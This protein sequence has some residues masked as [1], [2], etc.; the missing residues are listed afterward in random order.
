[1]RN[2]TRL[3][4]L[5]MILSIC[6]QNTITWANTHNLEEISVTAQKY[7]QDPQSV[8]ISLDHFSEV[9]LEDSKINNLFDLLTFSPNTHMLER[10]CEHI[11]VIRGIS[12]FRGC[13]YSPAAFYV[14]EVSYPLHYMQNIELFEL[15]RAEILK[16]PQGTL[17]GRNAESGV[18]SLFTKQP[19]NQVNGNIS[20]DY[21]NYNTLRTIAGVSGPVIEDKLFLGLSGMYY[22]TNGYVE[23]IANGDDKAADKNRASGRANLRW[24]PSESWD[25]S[26]LADFIT[27]DDHG[28]E[29]RVLSGPMATEPHKNRRDTDAFL[30]QDWNS[31]TLRA[32]YTTDT[33]KVVSVTNTLYQTLEKVNDA[34]LWDNPGMKAINPIDMTERQYSQELRVSST[35][36]SPLQWLLGAYGFIE[37]SHFDYRYE[38]LSA[39]SIYMRPVTDVD[40]NGYA[41]FGQATYTMF[42]KLHLTLGLRFDHQSMEGDLRDDVKKVR[43]SKD[44]EFNEVLPKM[45]LSYD[46][47]PD[48]M[49]YA[50]AAKGYMVG[51]YNWGLTGTIDTFCFDP[52]Y[53]WNYEVG[54][55]SKWLDNKLMA[56]LSVFYIS[57]DDKQVSELHPTIAATTITNAAEA[58]SKGFEFQ[59][60]AKPLSCLDIFGGF[61]YTEATFDKFNATVWNSTGTA[62]TTKNYE[63]NYLTYAPK[64]TYNFGA[65]YTADSGIFARADF[66]GTGPFFGDA[67]NKAEQNSYMTVNLQLGYKT[68]TLDFVLW[69]KNAFDEEYLTFLSPFRQSMVGID[70][71][72]QTFGASLTYRF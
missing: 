16:G 37:D 59:L 12:P 11:V 45:S 53:T 2:K 23:N 63:G 1:M 61:G 56:N 66:L 42:D 52:E 6:A 48:V 41:F 31:Q 26:L 47:D 46:I 54:V 33:V 68:N 67:A 44:L 27:A 50:S 72:P 8:P 22:S 62:L 7:E 64:Y 71:P 18:I 40:T 20:A 57:I 55:K 65:Q 13:T 70:G 24:T 3:T 17:Y 5:V 38:V 58:T 14:D 60:Q 30:R 32:K 29:S 28:G 10:S 51:G 9:Q 39:N 21:G 4:I 15:E 36:D 49:V 25:I 43:Y 35:Y 69:M 19:G 34:D